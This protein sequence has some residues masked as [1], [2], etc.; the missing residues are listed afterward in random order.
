MAHGHRRHVK[1]STVAVRSV[2]VWGVVGL[3]AGFGLLVGFG[4]AWPKA[5][6]GTVG[7]LLILL[8][9]Y[10]LEL[11]GLM[12][13]PTREEPRRSDRPPRH[14]RRPPHEPPMP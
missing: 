8:T 7:L 2:V 6:L 10:G 14:G 13:A 12:R 9:A 4:V 3:G 1:A 11:S 5:L